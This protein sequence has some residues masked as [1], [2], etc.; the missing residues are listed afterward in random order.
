MPTFNGKNAKGGDQLIRSL[1]IWV[2]FL[3][4]TLA[5]FA[6]VGEHWIEAGLLAIGSLISFGIGI[7]GLIDSK[8]TDGG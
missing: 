6:A 7:S 2:T 8:R 5:I 1:F 3:C 4:N